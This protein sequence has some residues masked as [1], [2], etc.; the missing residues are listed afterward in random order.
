M[1]DNYKIF[2]E[3]HYM[4][5]RSFIRLTLNFILGRN[6]LSMI[7]LIALFSLFPFFV[8]TCLLYLKYFLFWIC[9]LGDLFVK[10]GFRNL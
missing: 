6:V 3:R 9:S 4:I 2:F 8:F 10:T 5:G 1:H 7:N